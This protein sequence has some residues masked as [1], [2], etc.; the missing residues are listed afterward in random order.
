[1]FRSAKVTTKLIGASAATLTAALVVG[2]SFIAW[3]ASRITGDLARSEAEAVAREQAQFVQ[4]GL[5]NGLKA[6]QTLASSLTGMKKAGVI[7]REAWS[8]VVENLTLTNKDLAGTW[9]VVVG[10]KL[11]GRDAELKGNER[12]AV[13]GQWQPYYFRKPDGTLAY[14]P[15]EEISVGDMSDAGELWFNGAYVSGKDYMTE[16]YSWD[17]DGKTVTGVSFSSPIRDGATVIGVAGG[18][19]L[20]TPLS[21][22]LGNQR[23]LDTGSV[24]LLSQNGVWI[25]HADPAVLGKPWSEGRAEADLAVQDKLL[26]AVKNGEPFS[27][28]GYS[29]TLG[30][31]VH[32]IVMPVSVTGTDAKL[33]VVVNVPLS[34]LNAASSSITTMIVIVGVVLLIVVALSIYFVGNTIVRRPLERAVGS[35]QALIDRR[36]DE[37]IQDTDRHDE[38]GEI[39]KALEVFREK[40]QQAE[41]LT[42]EQ[43]EAQRQQLARA[44]RISELSQN[45]DRQISELTQTV[46]HQ[47]QDLNAASMTLTAGADDTSEKSTAV[48]AASEEASSNVETVASAAEELMASVGEISRQMTQSTEIASHAVEQ[49]QS[50]NRKIEGLAEAANRISEVVKLIT[51]IAEQTNLLAL[52]ATIEAARAGEAGKG[53][54]V[55]AA[56]VK[57]LANQTAKATEEISLQIQSVQTETAGSVDAIKGISETIEKMNE[58]SS[59]IQAS[60]EQ[61]GLATDEIARNIQEASNGTQEVAQNIVKVAAS[62]DDTGNAARQVSASAN[63]LQKEADR[64]KQEVEGFLANVRQVA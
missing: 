22:V 23:P 53:F 50:T 61:Q 38:I 15:I 52:N 9:G 16:P 26:T 60:V 51:D 55:V 56:E 36:Y 18:D 34:T 11:D 62:A 33:A 59:S 40:A 35:I 8:S 46:M 37:P 5:E 41:A 27:Y 25:A 30:T 43:E 42:A 28:D 12:W 54:A 10:D 39:S 31:E 64:L 4:R 17:A 57:E 58:I 13:G 44:G 63:V 49:A 24:H 19:I 47:V 21:D 1:M 6:S 3:E 2:I 32:R 20:L 48:A 45:F 7:D 14:R 29:N